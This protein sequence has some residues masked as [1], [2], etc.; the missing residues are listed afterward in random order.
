MCVIRRYWPRAGAETSTGYAGLKRRLSL[1]CLALRA[2]GL[3]L[4]LVLPELLHMVFHFM[5]VLF[6]NVDDDFANQSGSS[7]HS[8][9]NPLRQRACGRWLATTAWR[10]WDS[11]LL[12]AVATS[13]RGM[14]HHKSH[15]MVRY[16]K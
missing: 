3:L 2:A 6:M 9:S 8:H 16:P 11:S 14:G 1:C 12:T 4:G 7:T 5:N 15:R 10:S 13:R